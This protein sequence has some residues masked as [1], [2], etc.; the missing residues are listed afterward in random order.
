[1]NADNGANRGC[2]GRVTKQELVKDI[3]IGTYAFINYRILKAH[4]NRS[5]K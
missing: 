4:M 5:Q 3:V 1:M 2:W